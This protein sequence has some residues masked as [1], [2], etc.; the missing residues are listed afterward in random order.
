[1]DPE[2]TELLP[3]LALLSA[4]IDHASNI[5]GCKNVRNPK[6]VFKNFYKQ[7]FDQDE[8]S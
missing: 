3:S 8:C 2:T 5:A 1:M 7:M 4:K 6:K